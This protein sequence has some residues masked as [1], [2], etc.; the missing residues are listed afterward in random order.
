MKPKTMG[1]LSFI[2]SFV[3]F[4]AGFVFGVLAVRKLK[5]GDE[6]YGF[7]IAGIALSSLWLMLTMV[8]GIMMMTFLGLALS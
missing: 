2:F 4:P 5:Q 7:A 8:Y 6:G 3:F 1:I